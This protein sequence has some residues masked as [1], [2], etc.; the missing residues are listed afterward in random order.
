MDFRILSSDQWLYNEN[1]KMYIEVI[2]MDMSDRVK[3]VI[4][5]N[6]ISNNGVMLYNGYLRGRGEILKGASEIN[7]QDEIYELQALVAKSLLEGKDA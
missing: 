7:N 5:C 4:A 6:Y 2:G 3:G 1:E